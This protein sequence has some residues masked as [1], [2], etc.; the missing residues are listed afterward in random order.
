MSPW[1][2]RL[3]NTI[4]ASIQK[5]K[6]RRYI[7]RRT[8]IQLA[9]YQEALEKSGYDHQLT[10]KDI[11][12]SIKENRLREMIWC[13]S[14]FSETMKTTISKKF[15]N[16]SWKHFLS[17]NNLHKIFNTNTIMLSYSYVSGIARVIKRNNNSKTESNGQPNISRKCN[18]REPQH[19][20]KKKYHPPFFSTTQHH[21]SV[22][23]I[24]ATLNS[25]N[26]HRAESQINQSE[27]T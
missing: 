10:Y 1:S 13:N 8:Y 2:Y 25:A 19:C 24:R 27:N 16:L 11:M 6:I 23:N 22:P 7:V 26:P 14:S 21:S 9:Q 17:T 18:C 3:A 4:H 15:I 20:S 12:M 5:T